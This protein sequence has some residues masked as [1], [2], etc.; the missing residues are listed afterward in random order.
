M[1]THG[2]GARKR[3]KGQGHRGGRGMSGSGKRGDHKKTLITKK[4]GN[5]YFGKQ[6]VTSR[7]T[8]RDIRQRINVGEIQSNLPKYL[9]IDS[10]GEK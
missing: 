5:N 6:G 7:G 9:K 1:G 2:R 8:K 10:N 4:Y 3:A